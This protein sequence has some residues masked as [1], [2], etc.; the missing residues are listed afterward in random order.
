MKQTL[1]GYIDNPMGKGAV[2]PQKAMM[3]QTYEQKYGQVMV[4]EA[5]KFQCFLF[6]PTKDGKYYIHIKVP[7]ESLDKFYYDVVIEFYPGNNDVKAESH[8]RNYFCRFY[9]N[10]PSFVYTYVNAFKSQDL[11]IRQLSDKMSKYAI[12]NAAVIRNPNANIGYV[13]T[14]YFAY[15]YIKDHGLYNKS[16]YDAGITFNIGALKSNIT[17]ADDKIAEANKITQNERKAKA[18]AKQAEKEKKRLENH[19]MSKRA[20]SIKKT[21]TTDRVKTTHKIGYKKKK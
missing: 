14:I 17:H 12:K 20:S 9:S 10:D 8:L 18:A 11:F 4:K 7:S 2:F 19:K 6:T 21:P 1:N 15:L 16:L 13:K 5:G 3:Q